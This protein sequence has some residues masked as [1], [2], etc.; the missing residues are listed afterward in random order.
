MG[1]MALPDI[2]NH[3]H[4]NFG[5][6]GIMDQQLALRWVRQNIANFGGNPNNVAVGGQSAGAS[7]TGIHMVSPL[8]TGLFQ[9]GICESVCPI[10]EA[11][12][13]VAENKGS[14]FEAAAGCG[15]QSTPAARMPACVRFPRRRLSHSRE[16]QAPKASTSKGRWLMARFFPIQPIQAWHTGAFNKP[17]TIMNGRVRDEQKLF[18]CYYGVL[19]IIRRNL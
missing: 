3:E 1:F 9:H 13:S 5:N 11:E 18:T 19:R 7:D 6:Y 12:L 14:A 16:P 17:M 4:H 10:N 2:D 8:S 15:S